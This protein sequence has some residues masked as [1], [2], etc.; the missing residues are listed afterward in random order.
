MLP[1]AR[2]SVLRAARSQLQSSSRTSTSRTSFLVCLA[3]TLALLEQRDGK[4]N[5]SSLGA[6]TA[7]KQIGGSIT[8]FIAGKNAKAI[9]KEASK[10]E[11][12][13]K[14]LVADN[15]AYDR[16]LPENWAPLLVENIK[17]GGFTHVIVGHSAFGKNLLPRVAAL[18]DVQQMSDVMGIT[19]EDSASQK[20][21]LLSHTP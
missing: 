1:L 14:I 19:S 11:G 17:K 3:S 6:V 16:G 9:A 21:P 18:L 4:L 13:D 2:Q 10:V 15:E 20:H 5:S 7:G 8:G 12:L